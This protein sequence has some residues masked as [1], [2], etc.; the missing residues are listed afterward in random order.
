M[1]TYTGKQSVLDEALG[2]FRDFGFQLIESDD[3]LLELWFKD[4]RIATYNQTAWTNEQPMI[5]VIR[6]GCYNFLINTVD[7]AYIVRRLQQDYQDTYGEELR[8]NG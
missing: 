7:P 1:G 3:H 2:D 6:K 5:K 8:R 4:K